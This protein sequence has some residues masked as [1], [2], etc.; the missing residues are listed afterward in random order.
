MPESANYGARTIVKFSGLPPAGVEPTLASA[1][2]AS[3]LNSAIAL[4]G[5]SPANRNPPEGSSVGDPNVEP[6]AKGEP[7]NAVRD[8]FAVSTLNPRM[9]PEGPPE[10]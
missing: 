2:V 4:L 9:P 1:P 5:K 3:T 8:P 10:R 6:N 7:G